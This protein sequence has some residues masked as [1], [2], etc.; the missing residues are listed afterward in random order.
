MN[1]FSRTEFLF[2]TAAMERLAQARVAVFGIGG[3]GGYTVE[4]LA[5]SGVGALDLIDNDTV[6]TSNLNRQIIATRA[7]IGMAK[8]DAAEERI[9]LLCRTLRQGSSAVTAIVTGCRGATPRSPGALLVLTAETALGTV[10]GGQAEH[11]IIGPAM[12]MLRGGA[13]VQQGW[14]QC[15]SAQELRLDT[16]S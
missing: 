14:H 4:A 6:C 2:G 9:R 3:V 10:G 7:T 16:P 11:D 15:L 8:V 13:P 12:E 5:R 1:A